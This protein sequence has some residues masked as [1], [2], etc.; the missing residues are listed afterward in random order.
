MNSSRVAVVA[1]VLLAACNLPAAADQA[2]APG[3]SP[4]AGQ[5]IAPPTAGSPATP[6]SGSAAPSAPTP[7]PQAGQGGAPDVAT[8]LFSLPQWEQAPAGSTLTYGFSRKTKDPALGA[9][10]DDHIVLKL[11]AGDEA[12]SRT[13]DVKMFS[14][15]NAKA[16]GPFP[17]DQQ[18]P[19][20]LLVLENNVQELSKLFKANPRYLKNAIR[21]AWRNDAQ[22]ERTDITVNGKPTPG[23]RISVHPFAGDPEAGKMMGLDGMVYTVEIAD[24]VP[25]YIADIDIHA[26][27]DGTPKFSETLRYEA[28]GKP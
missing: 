11:G 18:N 4:M 25:G 7:P 17:S 12:H 28:I 2:G 27:A 8:L 1:S 3:A 22:I 9:S 19:V 10:F 20:L 23:T 13:A 5:P 24:S 14:G 16:A 26:P 21:K 6:P 15:A